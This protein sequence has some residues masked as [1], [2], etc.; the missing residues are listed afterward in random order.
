MKA[1]DRTRPAARPTTRRDR[2]VRSLSPARRGTHAP[3]APPARA[4]QPVAPQPA[5]PPEIERDS[6]SSTALAEII[7]RAVHATTAR[8]TAGLSPITLIGAYLDWAAHLAFSPGK[9]LH[10]IDKAMRKYARLANYAARCTTHHDVEPC[11]VPLPQDRRF[12]DP[13]WQQLPYSMIYQSFL[14]VQQWWYNA[15]T[16]VRGVR[17]EDEDIVEFATRQFLDV[18]SPSNFIATNPL[19]LR[20]TMNSGG[21]N[22]LQGFENFVEDW[23]AKIGGRKPV[24]VDAFR[25][26]REVAVTPGKVVYRNRLIELI[27]Y[28]P[29]TATVRAEPILIIPAW[30]MK[31]YILDLSPGNSLVRYFVSQGHTVFM[32]SWKNPGPEDRDLSM[33]HYRELGVMAALDAINA[34]VPGAKVHATGYCIGG[35]LLAIAAAA[36]ARDGDTRLATTTFFAAQTDFTEAGE[37]KLFINES[38][39]AFLED[40]MWEQGFLDTT[41]MAGAFQLLRS[42]DLVWS[43]IVNDYLMGERAP[44]TDLMAWNADATRMPYRMHSEYLRKLFLDNALAEGRFEAGGSVVALS[45]L[46]L[47]M[48]V[49]GTERDHVAPWQSVYKMNLL[50]DAEVT[51]V[52]TNGGHNAG[53]VSEPGHAGRH[54]EIATKPQRAT[55]VEPAAWLARATRL[56]GSWWPEWHSWLSAHSSA[57][58]PP[59][60]MGA[61]GKYVPS[62]DAPGTYV[63][64]P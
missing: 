22:L 39:V 56:E 25:V 42:N 26:G 50:S 20:R 21:T 54:Y 36:M 58:V 3:A 1:P 6:Y 19:V 35:T 2:R 31:Y 12:V 28:A 37:L 33:E 61:E 45:D 47:P 15:T 38:Q 63:M 64:Q 9:R 40:A 24:G 23:D 59:P 41:Q 5:T 60:T 48:F 7:D 11:I 17:R 44:M 8:L 43:R 53:V 46:Q 30:I 34:V 4:P 51:F 18:W 57:P 62:A 27:Q 13:S 55:Y 52:L 14:L 16:D 49:L 29:A 10:L 32:I